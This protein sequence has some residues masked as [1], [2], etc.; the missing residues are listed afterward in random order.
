[1]AQEKPKKKRRL[2][3]KAAVE[4]LIKYTKLVD[5]IQP[6]AAFVEVFDDV[7]K[8][9]DV[10][11]DAT[12]KIQK[13]PALVKKFNKAVNEIQDM[14][15]EPINEALKELPRVVELLNNKRREFIDV[16]KDLV[17]TGRTL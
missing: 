3:R 5:E 17:R 11:D 4:K 14:N 1:M 2:N 8:T 6:L 13:L 16:D 7:Q 15:I 12:T 9:V 10:I